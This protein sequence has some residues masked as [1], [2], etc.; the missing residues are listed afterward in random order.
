MRQTQATFGEKLQFKAYGIKL[1]AMGLLAKLIKMRDTDIFVGTDA[2]DSLAEKIAQAKR[3]KALI[4]TTAGTVKRGQI[5][6][7]IDALTTRGVSSAVYDGIIPDPTYETIRQ[8]LKAQQQHSCDC[9]IAFGGGSAMDAVKTIILAATNKKPLEKLVG[10]RKGIHKPLPFYAVP[11]TSGT[12]SEVTPVAVI[13]EDGTHT[14]RFIVDNRTVAHA[15][16]LDPTLSA[17]LPAS[18]TAET[19]MDALAHAIEAY[20]SKLSDDKTDAYAREAIEAIFQHLPIVVEDGSNLESREAMAR[21]S[22][23]AGMAFRTALL[24]YVHAI[25]HQLGAIYGTP[26]GLGN[27]ML[28]PL[29]VEYSKDAATDK[30][31]ELAVALNLGKAEQS[32]EE[33]AD[34]FVEALKDFNQR[35]NIPAKAE[36]LK[37]DDLPVIAE[38]AFDEALDVHAGPKYMGKEDI[39]DLLKKLM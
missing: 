16:A 19:G 20:I 4:V 33:L 36:A 30:L 1:T 9:V 21:A 32:K 28:L 14:K 24:G 5:Q 31:A 34:L 39:I 12:A 3:K 26:H 2:I 18:I 7:L 22:L 8:G 35:V 11:T 23:A 15:A 38:R 25:S 17:S 13:S 37:A 6:P 27:A 10:I 29:V